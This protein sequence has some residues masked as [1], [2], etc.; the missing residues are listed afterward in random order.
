MKLL[1]QMTKQKKEPLDLNRTWTNT[2]LDN[3]GDN[4]DVLVFEVL[5]D[6]DELRGSGDCKRGMHST[7]SDMHNL[8]AQHKG[9]N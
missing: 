4:T 3:R 1:H 2:R 9:G 6:E 5:Q 7:F 8:L